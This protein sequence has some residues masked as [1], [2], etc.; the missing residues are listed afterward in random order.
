MVFR[1]RTHAGNLLAEK[2]AP[3]IRGKECVVLA[4]PRGGVIVGDEI[5]NTLH[6][7]LDVIMSKKIT[8]PDHPE[9]AI[10]AVTYD[11]VL[12]RGSDWDRY[13]SDPRFEHEIIQKKNEVAR[14]IAAYRGSTEYNFGA[15]TV[16]LTDDGIATGATV[17]A[18]LKWLSQKGVADVILAIPVIPRST[19]ALLEEFGVVIVAIDT[20]HEFSS[21]GQFYRRFDQVPDSVVI[22]IIAKYRGPT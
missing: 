8:P 6:I 15:K 4:I 12:Y 2:I 20:P 16:I 13:S 9:Y 18:I 11:G 22:D 1:D 7:P 17:C 21:V 5:A 10:G 19:H 3:L 14:Q